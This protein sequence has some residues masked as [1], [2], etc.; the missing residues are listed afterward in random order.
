MIDSLSPAVNTDVLTKNTSMKLHQTILEI[1]GPVSVS[2]L[3][4][5]IVKAGK[6]TNHV[7]VLT[8]ARMSEFFKNGL[9]SSTLHL[10]DPLNFESKATSTALISA[11]NALSADEQVQLAAYLIDCIAA[12][13]SLLANPVVDPE[14]WIRFVLQHQR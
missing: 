14:A 3:L 10:E 9:K 1:Q 8:L 12:G 6:A 5:E 7:H 13:E 11:I 4:S 2:L